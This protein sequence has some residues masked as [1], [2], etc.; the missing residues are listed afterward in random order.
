M[1]RDHEAVLHP[2]EPV[3]GDRDGIPVLEGT[4]S[5]LSALKHVLDD[6]TWRKL[7]A[8]T[9][10]PGV[11][12]DVR[13]SWRARLG[14]GASVD[15]REGLRLL[16]DYGVPTVAS[17]SAGSAS[18]AVEA[19]EALGYPVALKTA[20]AGVAHK[21]DANGVRLGIEGAAELSI[22]YADLAA[23]LGPEVT[24]AT[25]APPGVEMA[26]GIVRDRAFGPLVVAAAG[27]VLVE[28][29][30][31]RALGLPPLDE[32]V[33]LRLIDRLKIRP[34]LDGVRGAVPSDVAALAHAVSRMSVIAEDLGDMVDA[35]DVNPVIVSPT[36][37][38]A[39]DALVV[40]RRA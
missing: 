11:A 40:S 2:V 8:A 32:A 26:L 15:E 20:A 18:A 21:S 39:V 13:S 35:I 14:T 16:A 30:H 24:V 34:I 12:E 28:V 36:G 29:L 19:A 17:R 38:V 6:A 3:G 7:P 25:M 22:A 33:A 27:G 4:P 9:R 37:C 10:P 31:D 1:G 23:R 5:G